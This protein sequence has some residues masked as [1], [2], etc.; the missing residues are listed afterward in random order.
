MS[1]VTETQMLR[2]NLQYINS[3]R[4]VIQK[5]NME[6]DSGYKVHT[7]GDSEASATIEK[8]RQALDRMDSYKNRTASVKSML[9]F[10]DDALSQVSDLINRARE[11]AQQ[12]SNETNSSTTRAQMAEE[13]FQIRNHLVSI[14]N[15]KYQGKYV[16]GGAGADTNAPYDPLSY[17]TG[18]GEAAVRYAWDGAAGRTTTRDVNISDDFNL[19]IDTPGNTVF[20]TAIEGMERLGRALS[21]LTTT[22]A[23]GNTSATGG[24]YTFPTDFHLQTQD[25][26]NCLDILDRAR[27]QDI[28]PE[29]VALGGK[30]RRI[31]TAESLIELTKTSATEALDKLQN[32]D[33]AESAS[34]LSQA[35]TILQASLQVTAKVLNLSIMDYV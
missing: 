6:V 9:T 2:S 32:A 7:P 11:I 15:S 22:P 19:T 20:D 16:W 17:T 5:L 4:S 1:R 33:I 3:S 21:G 26:S 12:A 34:S 14:A 8:Y 25:I 10:Q 23:S 31:D 24:T 13:V 29:R 28:E 30:L 18:T 27:T 35:Q